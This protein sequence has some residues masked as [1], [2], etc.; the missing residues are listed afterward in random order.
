MS[1]KDRFTDAVKKAKELGEQAQAA[2]GQATEGLTDKA[3][4][5]IGDTA[6]RLAEKM[7]EGKQEKKDE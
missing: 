4:T 1:L 7:K 2:A 6:G 3:K 5:I